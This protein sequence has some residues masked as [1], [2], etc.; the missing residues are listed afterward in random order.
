MQRCP[1][2]R[3]NV[4]CGTDYREGFINIDGSSCLFKVDKT[5]D[6]CS[7]SLLDSFEQDSVHY[8]LANDIIE[9]FFHWEAVKLLKEFYAVLKPSGKCEIRAP[10][11]EYII[12]SWRLSLAQKMNLL[13]GGQDIPQGDNHKMNESRKKYPHYFCHKYGWTKKSIEKV[14]TEIGFKKIKIQRVGV[15]LIAIA[16]KPT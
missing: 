14:L 15:N 5:I 9:H 6:L 8:I 1:D 4:G 3:L 10:D 13:Y 12:K 11:T 16:E 2:I 7:E